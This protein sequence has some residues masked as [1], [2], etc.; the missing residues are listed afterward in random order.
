MLYASVSRVSWLLN[1]CDISNVHIEA[2][3]INKIN[4]K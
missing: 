4:L 1:I 2:I 3:G